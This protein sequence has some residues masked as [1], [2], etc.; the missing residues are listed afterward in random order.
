[1]SASIDDYNGKPVQVT[2]CALEISCPHYIESRCCHGCTKYDRCRAKCLNSPD[3][4]G[5][6]VESKK[7]FNK[8]V[9]RKRFGKG[10]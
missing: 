3:K 10:W 6:N 8:V 7:E 2:F 4:C 5:Q 1:M 9:Y